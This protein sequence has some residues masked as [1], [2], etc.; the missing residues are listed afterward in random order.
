MRIK[1]ANRIEGGMTMIELLTMVVV[2]VIWLAMLL[3]AL[4]QPHQR[5]P[6]PRCVNNLKEIGAAFYI[7]KNDNSG[8]YP[9]ELSTNLGGTKEYAFGP[10][11]FRHFQALQNE[12]GQSPKVVVC[13]ED[14]GRSP[15]TNFINFNNSNL[16]YFVGVTVSASDKNPDLF[17]SGD[18][19]LTN[20][21][22][23]GRALFLLTTNGAVGW[24]AGIHGDKH[25][26][27][28]NILFTDGRVEQLSTSRLET[29][30]RKPGVASGPLAIP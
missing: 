2:L 16:S 7:W 11:V 20:A 15:S 22:G 23:A 19:N 21:L 6:G 25:A 4:N 1:N 24:S 10:E 9:M 17:L 14:K 8:A 3:P 30:L 5:R 27:A 28:G 13:P 18:R 29:A 26:P 12:F